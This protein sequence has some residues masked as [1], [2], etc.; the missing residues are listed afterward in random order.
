[1]Q[2]RTI[3]SAVYLSATEEKERERQVCVNNYAFI[4]IGGVSSGAAHSSRAEVRRH[5]AFVP[6]ARINVF[7]RGQVGTQER[8]S[9]RSRRFLSLT[10]AQAFPRETRDFMNETTTR[11]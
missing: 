4:A 6:E 5:G 7:S 11:A 1:M 9:G 3:R 2:N 8:R 10:R